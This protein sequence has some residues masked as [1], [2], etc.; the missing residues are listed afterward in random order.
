MRVLLGIIGAVI[1]LGIFASVLRTLVI[2]RPTR[3]VS[4]ASSSAR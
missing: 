3:P 1:V 2:P 4:P